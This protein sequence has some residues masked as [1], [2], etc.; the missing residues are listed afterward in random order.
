MTQPHRPKPLSTARIAHVYAAALFAFYAV[1]ILVH[2]QPPLLGDLSDWT[3]S[4]V[5]VAR[6][7]H[8]LP[9]PLHSIRFYPVP[10]TTNTLLLAVLS[11]FVR[12]QL[13]VR[14]YLLLQLVLSY[15]AMRALA[16]A[17][18]AP[19]WVWLVAPGAVFFG[20][21]F[22]YGLF[23]FQ[24]GVCFVFLLVAML[25]RRLDDDLPDWPIGA[26]LV[27]LFYTH[28]VTFTLALVLLFFFALQSQRPRI[29]WQAAL[30]LLL[31]VVY[32]VCR[33]ASGNPDSGVGPPRALD[34]G[35]GLFWA[36]KM[37]TFAKSFGFVNPTAWSH[38][39][40]LASEDRSLFLF[41]FAVD[42]VLCFALAALFFKNLFMRDAA[43]RLPFLR[44]TI[45]LTIPVYLLLP[46]SLLGIADPGSRVM[47][48][49]FWL[50]LMVCRANGPFTRSLARI[51]AAAS[52]LLALSGA[53]LFVH[54]PWT[55]QAQFTP[56]HLPHTVEQFGKAPYDAAADLYEALDRGDFTRAVFPTGILNNHP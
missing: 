54:L 40:A 24:M 34:T 21:N 1:I 41:L 39:V 32:T 13:A 45:A 33:F 28:M 46:T 16:R 12:W 15:Y 14:V 27:L 52:L 2:R 42:L 44:L 56:A 51:A 55:R 22:W 37:N 19:T 29:L 6:H 20:I 43:D 53:Y 4:G 31:V 7:M 9:D 30:P 49:S 11:Y 3:Y 35:S 5:L 23:A 8:G 18:D 48:S 36:Y 26:M 47:Q 17:A 50:L 10:N 25:L 38:S